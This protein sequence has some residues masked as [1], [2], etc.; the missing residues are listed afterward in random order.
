LVVTWAKRCP[1]G[2]LRTY[3]NSKGDAKIQIENL[4]TYDHGLTALLMA[5]DVTDRLSSFSLKSEAVVASRTRLA[6]MGSVESAR[7]GAKAF[8]AVADHTGSY[9]ESLYDISSSPH[10]DVRQW[11]G[12]HSLARQ[13]L[14]LATVG[15]E[16]GRSAAKV[17]LDSFATVLWELFK[18]THDWARSGADG[19][20]LQRSIRALRI[21]SYSDTHEK[22]LEMTAD[23]PRLQEYLQH[24]RMRREGGR[25]RVIEVSVLDSGP[26]LAARALLR[27]PTVASAPTGSIAREYSAVVDCLRTHFSTSSDSYRGDGLHQVFLMLDALKGFVRIRTGRLALCRDF[28]RDPYFPANETEPFLVDWQTGTADPVAAAPVEGTVLTMLFPVSYE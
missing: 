14:Q 21:E 26:G 17:V 1:N 19:R 2:V 13:M 4:A 7:R 25:S 18:N 28:I 5:N 12:F 11:D 27:T 16:K 8:L 20:P 9:P 23:E 6:A 10:P 3:V 15:P 24:P 22:H